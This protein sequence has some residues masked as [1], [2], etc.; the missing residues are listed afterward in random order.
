VTRQQLEFVGIGEVL[1][2]LF[3]DGHESLGGAPLNT[4]VHCHRLLQALDLGRAVI[5]SAVGDDIRGRHIHNTLAAEGF[6]TDYL[7]TS[8]LRTGWSDVFVRNGE[9]GFE[10]AES[11]AWDDIGTTPDTDALA[12]RCDAVC[13]GSLAQRA[14]PSRQTIGRFVKLARNALI[15]YDVNLR[16]NTR[17][18]SRGFSREIIEHSCRAATAVKTNEHELLA[19]AELF[20]I[21]GAAGGEERMWQAMDFLL[22]EF[23]LQAVVVTRGAQNTLLLSRGEQIV[24]P[25]APPSQAELHPVGAGDA[26]SAGMLFGMSQRWPWRT[27]LELAGKMG[28]WVAYSPSDIPPLPEEIIEFARNHIRNG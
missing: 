13:F 21:R 17:S 27:S 15:L 11:A 25:T 24:M 23:S 4:A 16:T 20:A 12:E 1:M 8:R 5:V 18:G 9:P 7:A 26:F 2:D 10:I 22:R 6:P 28:T 3:E 14:A 19:L